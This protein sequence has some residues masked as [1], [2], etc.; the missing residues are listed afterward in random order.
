MAR[1]SASHGPPADAQLSSAEEC[2][3]QAGVCPPDEVPGESGAWRDVRPA[4]DHALSCAGGRSERAIHHP[5]SRRRPR[6][7]RRPCLATRDCGQVV[8]GECN[9]RYPRWPCTSVQHNGI[10]KCRRLRQLNGET[11]VT[12]WTQIRYSERPSRGSSTSM[13]DSGIRKPEQRGGGRAG[14][15]PRRF[16]RR[17]RPSR[18]RRKR[19]AR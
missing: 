5:R 3:G 7:F 16:L 10:I 14:F 19:S 1:N 11:R 2:G 15:H 9:V 12:A 18:R 17:I 13:A 8:Q 4:T 6:R